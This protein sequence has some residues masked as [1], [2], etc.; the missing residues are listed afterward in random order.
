MLRC[1]SL[2]CVTRLI[3]NGKTSMK[4]PLSSPQ[5]WQCAWHNHACDPESTG[6]LLY[7]M[8]GCVKMS[9]E[10]A[11]ITCQLILQRHN[12]VHTKSVSDLGTLC[13]FCMQCECVRVCSPPTKLSWRVIIEQDRQQILIIFLLFTIWFIACICVRINV[14][15]SMC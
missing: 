14:W 3:Y 8:H 7:H 12:D 11:V 10:N 4:F 1:S 6:R 15:L 2:L 5:T 9:V 13:M